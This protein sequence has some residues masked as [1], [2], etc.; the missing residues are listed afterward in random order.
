M[1]GGKAQAFLLLAKL[2]LIGFIN[3][4]PG[5]MRPLRVGIFLK[6]VGPVA[7]TRKLPPSGSGV[8]CVFKFCASR[9]Q[10]VIYYL[11]SEV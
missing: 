7:P 6:A 9:Y 11:I 4:D 2:C 1:R 5:I 10:I 8:R 3:G